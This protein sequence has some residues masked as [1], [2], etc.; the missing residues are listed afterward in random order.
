M[1]PVDALFGIVLSRCT[2]VDE[3]RSHTARRPSRCY[4]RCEKFGPLDAEDVR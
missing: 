1:P 4:Q 2:R 3:E